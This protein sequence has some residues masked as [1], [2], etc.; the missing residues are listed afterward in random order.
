MDKICKIC[1][2]EIGNEMAVEDD[3]G[4]IHGSQMECVVVL[5]ERIDE[6]EGENAAYEDDAG[7]IEGVL[8]IKDERIAELEQY[9]APTLLLAKMSNDL[10][11]AKQRIAE[12]EEQLRWRKY[13]EE[14]PEKDGHYLVLHRD[15]RDRAD[16]VGYLIADRD[17]WHNEDNWQFYG[18][19]THWRPLSAPPEVE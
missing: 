11:K 12:L 14:K 9:P 7:H 5:Q 16:A 4:W 13:P 10:D 18:R 1:G 15:Y 6:L 17:N 8:R 3:G 19:I 2:V